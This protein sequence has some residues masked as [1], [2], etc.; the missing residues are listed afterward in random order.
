MFP[1]CSSRVVFD[2][3][4][5][6]AIATRARLMDMAATDKLLVAGMHLDF[7][8][9]GHVVRQGAGYAHVPVVWTPWI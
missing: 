4:G 9:F 5:P 7:P 8:V 6:A 2:G 1:E 3:D